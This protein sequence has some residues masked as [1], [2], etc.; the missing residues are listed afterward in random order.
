[1]T[2]TMRPAVP[3]AS[4]DRA[5]ARQQR[6]AVCALASIISAKTSGSAFVDRRHG[7]AAG[8][9]DRRPEVGNGRHR[10]RRPTPA[11]R[12]VDIGRQLDPVMPG[13]GEILRRRAWLL[14]TWQIAPS[15]SSR[16]STAPPSAPVPPVTT[17]CLPSTCLPCQSPLSRHRGSVSTDDLDQIGL[18]QSPR[19]R[20][21]A[22]GRPAGEAS[23]S[24]A[25]P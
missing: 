12:E 8:Q 18:F 2:L 4:I 23:R 19:A 7:K 25:M 16:A 17:I 22:S 20:S 6:K 13:E 24:A 15:S 3:D 21:S 5:A 11:S 14:G 10:R 9:M 1:M